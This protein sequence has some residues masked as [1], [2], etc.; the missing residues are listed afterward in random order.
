M[1]RPSY[2]NRSPFAVAAASSSFFFFFD[3]HIFDSLVRMRMSFKQF[4]DEMPFLF[5]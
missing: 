1:H 3:V 4:K 5:L 2:C